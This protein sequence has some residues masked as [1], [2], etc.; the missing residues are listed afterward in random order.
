M[1]EDK[2]VL[3]RYVIT[4]G[5]LLLA[6]AVMSTIWTFVGPLFLML[7]FIFAYLAL[8]RWKREQQQLIVV[9][10]DEEESEEEMARPIIDA[11]AEAEAEAED[12]DERAIAIQRADTGLLVL[13]F[14]SVAHFIMFVMSMIYIATFVIPVG[15][16]PFWA[17]MPE[18][19]GV[20]LWFIVSSARTMFAK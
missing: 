15:L 13:V 2:T 1:S 17:F 9:V 19:V 12:V 5:L 11:F 7:T 14:L 10:R 8:S 3:R 18:V 4:T 20:L 6:A 16:L